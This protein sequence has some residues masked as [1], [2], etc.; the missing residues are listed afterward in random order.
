[1]SQPN[2]IVEG[3]ALVRRYLEAIAEGGITARELLKFDDE[4]LLAFDNERFASLVGKQD[5]AEDLA[6]EE[7]PK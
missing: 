1:M 2:N 6:G 3:L 7:G 4:A 5:E